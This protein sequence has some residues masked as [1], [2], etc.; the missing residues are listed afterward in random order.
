MYYLRTESKVRAETV[1]DKV[2]RVA[3]VDDQ[4][5]IIYGKDDCPYCHMA[6]EEFRILNIPYD[7]IDIVKLGKTAAEVTGRKDVKTVPQIYIKGEY[8]GGYDEFMTHINKGHEENDECRACE[9]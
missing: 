6:K 4:R 8:I 2:A 7:F 9:G 5:N 3:L 1:A